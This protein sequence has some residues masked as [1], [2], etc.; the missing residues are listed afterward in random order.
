MNEL[1]VVLS[2]CADP[3]EA[4]RIARVVVSERLAAC[5]Q[6][7]PP[8]RSIYHWQG[9]LEISSEHLLLMKTSADRFPGLEARIK[10]LHSYE[11]PE[12]VAL[13]VGAVSEQYGAWL[14]DAIRSEPPMHAAGD[15]RG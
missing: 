15:R 10:D 12:I 8:M 7:M 11:V 1:M 4:E 9:G 14:L 6:I 3:D 13:P 2:T 5:V